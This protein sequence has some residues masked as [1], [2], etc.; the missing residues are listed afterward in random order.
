M[1]KII[2]LKNF[3]NI[4]KYSILILLFSL[5]LFFLPSILHFLSINR[6]PDSVR[7][8]KEQSMTKLYGDYMIE[9]G[10]IYDGTFY[11]PVIVDSDSSENIH[12]IAYFNYFNSDK[13]KK[14]VEKRYADGY[15]RNILWE[16]K[17]AKKIKE[18]FSDS[19]IKISDDVVLFDTVANDNKIIYLL[20]FDVI[21]LVLFF[22]IQNKKATFSKRR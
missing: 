10:K 19:N 12:I 20:F 2:L 9:Y 21:V 13:L 14:S 18:L 15:F 8:S 1:Y 5:N 6:T 11:V 17:K 7:C 16:K 22:I 3:N 4:I